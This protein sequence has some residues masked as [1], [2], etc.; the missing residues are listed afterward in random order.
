M[1][2]LRVIEGGGG[3]AIGL[4]SVHHIVSYCMNQATLIPYTKRSYLSSCVL[5]SIIIHACVH[6]MH[7]PHGA[8][9][10]TQ[11]QPVASMLVHVHL[12][13]VWNS[14]PIIL[15]IILLSAV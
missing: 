13:S 10:T 9:F 15:L 12:L 3:L 1:H 2:S 6:T 11:P 14:I 5:K 8:L 7:S 4:A